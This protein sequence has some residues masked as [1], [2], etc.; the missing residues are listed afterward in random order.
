MNQFASPPKMLFSYLFLKLQFHSIYAIIIA[1]KSK[2]TFNTK[3][4]DGTFKGGGDLQF[5]LQAL[6]Q[7]TNYKEPRSHYIKKK[8]MS[9]SSKEQ[10]PQHP[11]LA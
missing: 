3:V 2:K 10:V 1:K 8:Q 7:T 9:H 4:V 11:T 5:F 6:K